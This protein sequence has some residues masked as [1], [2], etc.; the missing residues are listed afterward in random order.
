MEMSNPPVTQS[1]AWRIDPP[2]GA[3]FPN[4]GSQQFSVWS[5]FAKQT[6]D[7]ILASLLLI[8]LFPVILVAGLLI[9]LT[10]RGPIFFCQTRLGRFGKP[11]TIYKLRTMR[12]LCERDSGP[13]WSKPGDTRITWIG[14][15]LRGTHVDEFPQLLNVLR[16]EM[17][18]VGPRPERPE[19]LPALEKAVPYYKQRLLVKPGI[20][21]LA[22]VQL[23]P[24][25][26]MNSVR[27]KLA[28]DLFYVSRR[29]VWLDLRLICCTAMQSLFIPRF[30]VGSVL[31]IPGGDKVERP[32]FEASSEL[33]LSSDVEES[34]NVE[35]PM[36][37]E[38]QAQF[39]S[40]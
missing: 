40:A 16:G 22:Q 24:D 29:Q 13:Q 20:T 12:H 26:D 25:T 32:Y 2:H 30:L 5:E 36:E 10:S 23:P 1:S 6:L 33:H 34:M 15:I 38:A 8:L 28:Y 19:F 35:T 39:Q 9:K 11:F 37:S 4:L 3:R 18:L 17:S 14:R 27:R 21:G 31:R 7:F